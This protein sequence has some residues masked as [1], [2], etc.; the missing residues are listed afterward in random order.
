LVEVVGA[1]VSPDFPTTPGAYD[2]TYNG[3][4]DAFVVILQI[5]PTMHV[6]SITPGYRPQ[7]AGFVVGARIQIVGHARPQG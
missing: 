6:A 3:K 5:A 7:R 2:R 1:T 4:F